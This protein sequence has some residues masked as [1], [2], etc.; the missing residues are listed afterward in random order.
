MASLDELLAEAGGRGSVAGQEIGDAAIRL[1][2]SSSG[3][4]SSG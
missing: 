4:G 3:A 1:A 2:S